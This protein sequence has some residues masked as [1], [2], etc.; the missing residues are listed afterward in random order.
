MNVNP[1]T[2]MIRNGTLYLK[3]LIGKLVIG[4]KIIVS[5]L[6]ISKILGIG[7]IFITKK[8]LVGI[9]RLLWREKNP[10]TV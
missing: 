10:N 8:E 6:K 5:L 2:M 4:K 9:C 1:V 3:D 7:P